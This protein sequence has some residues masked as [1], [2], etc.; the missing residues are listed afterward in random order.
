[1][2]RDPLRA[3]LLG[4]KPQ[5]PGYTIA[6]ALDL[7][8]SSVPVQRVAGLNLLGKVLA[9]A[10]R[11]GGTV[12]TNGN[13]AGP[14][15]SSGPPAGLTNEKGRAGDA[16]ASAPGGLTSPVRRRRS[17]GIAGAYGGFG[18]P[19]DPLSLPPPLPTGVAWQ[20]VWLHCTVDHDAVL[21]LRRC[22][23]DDHLPAAAASA[24]ALSS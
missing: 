2:E 16:S 17:V 1:M 7:A 10:K 3:G 12:S 15:S 4:A 22:L 20:D 21:M 13:G 5:S 9:R 11:W 23:D 14:V 18:A 8:R 19:S 6:E 24:G